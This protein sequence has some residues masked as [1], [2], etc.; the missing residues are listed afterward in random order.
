MAFR[1]ASALAGAVCAF[2]WANAACAEA[3]LSHTGDLLTL[4]V[5][6]GFSG[7]GDT[8]VVNGGTTV[9]R[10]VDDLVGGASLSLGYDFSK[11]GL[12]FRGDIE[13]AYRVRFDYDI[14]IFGGTN[15]D[16][17]NN[18]STHSVLANLYYDFWTYGKFSPYVGFGLGWARNTS[19]VEQTKLIGGTKETRE[20][21]TDNFAWALHAGVNY[22]LGRNWRFE[23]AYRYSYL[24]DIS[25]GT[26]SDGSRVSTDTFTSHDVILGVTYA[27]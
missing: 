12:P 4:R 25:S 5:I 26:F 17:E 22:R 20:E 23:C 18:L 6:G 8:D 21:S 14:R 19:D 15:A 13:Y 7:V 10:N 27:F 24:G 1:A 11:K 3:D 16:F 2:I 9:E